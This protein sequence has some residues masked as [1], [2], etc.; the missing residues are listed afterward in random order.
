MWG[1]EPPKQNKTKQNTNNGGKM[2]HTA[3]GPPA[4]ADLFWVCFGDPKSQA[5]G[6]FGNGSHSPGESGCPGAPP[7]WLWDLFWVNDDLCHVKTRHNLQGMG[8]NTN[9]WKMYL[10]KTKALENGS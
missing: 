5:I 7:A 10:G 1:L 8:S 6:V 9:T 4:T 3:G 2:L